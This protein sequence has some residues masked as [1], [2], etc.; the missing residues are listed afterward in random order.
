[1]NYV[2]T[3]SPAD[4]AKKEKQYLTKENKPISDKEVSVGGFEIL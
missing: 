3:L 4:D 2:P 1:M